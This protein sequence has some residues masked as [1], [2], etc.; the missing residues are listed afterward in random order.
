MTTVQWPPSRKCSHTRSPTR[1]PSFV[2]PEQMISWLAQKILSS[3]DSSSSSFL[4]SQKTTLVGGKG[5]P[6][7]VREKAFDST[8]KKLLAV[9]AFLPSRAFMAFPSSA[10]LFIK[11]PCYISQKQDFYGLYP[12]L[13]NKAFWV[14]KSLRTA[15]F[16]GPDQSREEKYLILSILITLLL[17]SDSRAELERHDTK[18][19]RSRSTTTCLVNIQKRAF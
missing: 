9:A 5:R 6:G 7:L 18:I 16:Q 1:K 4:I 2:S 14:I 17:S 12:F 8:Q 13:P 3:Q 11:G 15:Y 10:L 19:R